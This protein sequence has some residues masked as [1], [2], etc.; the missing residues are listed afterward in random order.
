MVSHTGNYEA[1]M[2]QIQRK[3]NMNGCTHYTGLRFGG[4]TQWLQEYT[5]SSHG[6]EPHMQA[7]YYTFT[8]GNNFL[9]IM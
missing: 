7:I 2:R 1:W 9:F 5:V 3:I 6:Y 8:Y 4:V